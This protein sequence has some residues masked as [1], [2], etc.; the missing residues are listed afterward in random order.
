MKNTNTNT[1][2][3]SNKKVFIVVLVVLLLALAVGYAAFSD[4]LKVS[5]TANAKGTFDLEFQ[6]AKVVTTAGVDTTNTTATIS[7]DKDTLTVNVADLAYPGAGTEFSV[8]IV[9][10]GSISA[11]VTDVIANNISGSDNIKIKG[12]DAINQSHKI[13]APNE[14]CNIHFTVEW[15][16]ESTVPLTN[17]VESVQYDLTLEYTQGTD[18]VQFTGNTSHTDIAPSNSI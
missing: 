11:E 18:N 3:K 13:L 9:N 1:Q 2:T 8:D 14:K 12:L 5:G 4:V 16:K 15:P 6:N 10:V 7:S 17:G